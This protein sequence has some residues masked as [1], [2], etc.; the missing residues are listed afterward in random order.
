VP[1]KCKFRFTRVPEGSG[2][3]PEACPEA[4]L[5]FV[6]FAAVPEGSGRFPEACPEAC[7]KGFLIPRPEAS[8]RFPEA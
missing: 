4:C 8:G 7:L 3:L 6:V 2:S 5:L 1:R